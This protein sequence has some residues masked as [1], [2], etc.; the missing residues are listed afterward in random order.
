MCERERDRGK[1]LYKALVK[2]AFAR[3]GKKCHFVSIS[4]NCLLHPNLYF[5]ICFLFPIEI[6]LDIQDSKLYLNVEL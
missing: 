1:I 3:K 5:C 2:Y 6:Q 4:I